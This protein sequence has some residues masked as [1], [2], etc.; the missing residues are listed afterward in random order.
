M[1]RKKLEQ[2]FSVPVE[3]TYMRC[4]HEACIYPARLKVGSKWVCTEHYGEAL[5]AP[6]EREAG[7]D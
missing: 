1:A 7:E 5:R 6:R 3:P 2:T 4:Q